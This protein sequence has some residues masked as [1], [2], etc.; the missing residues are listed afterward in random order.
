MACEAVR[1]ADIR[2]QESDIRRQKNI[3]VVKNLYPRSAFCT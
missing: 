2:R 1:E 3:S